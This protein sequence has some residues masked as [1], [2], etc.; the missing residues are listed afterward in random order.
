MRPDRHSRE[1]GNLAVYVRRPFIGTLLCNRGD[2]AGL[3]W[4]A[5]LREDVS[6]CF[7]EFVF[8]SER[9]EFRCDHAFGVDDECPRLG[10]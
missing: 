2:G 10:W 5:L 7:V 4:N 6:Q 1:G 8:G 3:S 9:L